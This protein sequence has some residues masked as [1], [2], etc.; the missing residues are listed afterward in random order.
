MTS[1]CIPRVF[2]Y[3]RYLFSS[4]TYTFLKRFCVR[5]S[6]S[7]FAFLPCCQAFLLHSSP[8]SKFINLH[9]P[10]SKLRQ[11]ISALP[12]HATPPNTD[13]TSSAQIFFSGPFYK[14]PHQRSRSPHPFFSVPRIPLLPRLGQDIQMLN[15]RYCSGVYCHQPHLTISGQ[16]SRK[17][18][19]PQAPPSWFLV[20]LE[21]HS[22][23]HGRTGHFL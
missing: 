22:R 14:A 10:V 15:E 5:L 4:K 3:F 20:T 9:R 7:S 1:S 12:L 18:S 2:T 23:Q 17:T 8:P 21:T 16:S 19:L 13:S 11:Q 6:P